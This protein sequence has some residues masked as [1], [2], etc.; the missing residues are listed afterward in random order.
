MGDVIFQSE[1]T[2]SW[3]QMIQSFKQ[4]KVDAISI[5]KSTLFLINSTELKRNL[6]IFFVLVFQ[7]KNKI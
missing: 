4:E 2:F 6:N 1:L 7:Q 3:I 5:E